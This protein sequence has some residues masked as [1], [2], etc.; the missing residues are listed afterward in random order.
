MITVLRSI[1][2]KRAVATLILHSHSAV[3]F[4]P[5]QRCCQTLR[6]RVKKDDV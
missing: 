1:V 5:S 6:Q 3:A 2:G 4:P